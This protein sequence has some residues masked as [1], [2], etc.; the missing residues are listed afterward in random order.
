MIMLSKSKDLPPLTVL[1]EL[2]VSLQ[3]HLPGMMLEPNL[4]RLS[5]Y[6]E[7][8]AKGKKNPP[9]EKPHG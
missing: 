2:M 3:S 7:T 4:K 9:P 1:A 8:D 5:R 6:D